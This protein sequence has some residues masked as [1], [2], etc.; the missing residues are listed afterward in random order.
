MG[1][2]AS[3]E[4]SDSGGP[5]PGP[6]PEG[7]LRAQAG[8]PRPPFRSGG[9]PGPEA[10]GAE[11]EGASAAQPGRPAQRRGPG[12]RAVLFGSAH[13][14][15]A[16][17]PQSIPARA[18][19][20]ANRS[21]RTASTDQQPQRAGSG[22]R[23]AR[24]HGAA[25]GLW[26]GNRTNPESSGG[27]RTEGGHG[28]G[29]YLTAAAWPRPAPAVS[30]GRHVDK[31]RRACRISKGAVSLSLRLPIHSQIFTVRLLRAKQRLEIGSTQPLPLRSLHSFSPRTF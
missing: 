4:S 24:P 10:E 22:E 3:E 15:A 18:C 21:R 31:R 25:A 19:P 30:R 14:A 29:P 16:T 2:E 13:T 26:R 28:A 1:E 9:G 11:A 7:R 6:T 23:P 5:R 8:A 27:G 20:E 17:A 12:A